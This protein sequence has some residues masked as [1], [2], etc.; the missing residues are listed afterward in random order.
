MKDSWKPNRK[1]LWIIGT[2]CVVSLLFVFF[3]QEQG[4][5]LVPL[6]T[7]EDIITQSVED[8]SNRDS[9]QDTVRDWEEFLWGMDPNKKDTDGNG[10]TDDKE[11]EIKKLALRGTTITSTSTATTTFTD[12]FSREFFV[13]F[14]ALKQS[15]NLTTSNIDQISKQSLEALTQ[16]TIAEKYSKKDL[17]LASSTLELRDTY[18]K[19][20]SQTGK[21]L[22]IKTLGRELELLNRAINKPRSDKL[23]TELKKIQQIYLTLAERTIKVT[24]PSSIQNTHL[25]LANTYYKL[26]ASI[27]GL[28]QIYDDP[29]ISIVYFSEYQKALKK[30]PTVMRA[31]EKYVN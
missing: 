23:I 21:G 1:T 4:K 5:N 12:T 13:A 14:S 16:A 2:L 15:G 28:T 26:G 18:K 20:I 9:D 3:R 6:L 31:I 29:A 22:A 7:Q 10:I 24:A 11:L 19:A 27:G 8:I 25:D 30:L 17:L